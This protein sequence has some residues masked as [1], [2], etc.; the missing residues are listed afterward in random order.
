MKGNQ[1]HPCVLFPVNP[2]MAENGTS[3]LRIFVL[4]SGFYEN[5]EGRDG[6]GH[7]VTRNSKGK[8][9]Y[10]GMFDQVQKRNQQH[11]TKRD[12]VAFFS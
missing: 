9:N 2:F 7:L 12:Q 1:P 6:A 4:V 3:L 5:S 11:H 10:K 8:V